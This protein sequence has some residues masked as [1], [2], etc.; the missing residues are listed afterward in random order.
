[1]ES[2]F[3]YLRDHYPQEVTSDQVRQMLHIS[4]RKCA[5]MLQNGWIRCEDNGKKTRRYTIYLEDVIAYAEDRAK[6]PE[7][8]AFPAIF[9]SGRAPPHNLRIRLN[10]PPICARGSPTSGAA[11]ATRSPNARSPH[12]SATPW[13]PSAA[14]SIAAG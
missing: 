14:G 10:R 11:S 4:K 6:H 3:S 12:F 13:T 1:M 8:Y 2:D 7:K 5:W 9:S